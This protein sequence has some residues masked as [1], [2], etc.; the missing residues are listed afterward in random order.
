MRKPIK[1]KALEGTDS[2]RNHN[3]SVQLGKKLDD[4]RGNGRWASGSG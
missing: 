2:T 4:R 1:L 3:R